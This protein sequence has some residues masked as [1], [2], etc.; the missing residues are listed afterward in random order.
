MR[1]EA[2]GR[3]I[4]LASAEQALLVM[5]VAFALTVIGTRWFLA[6]TGF[7]KIGGGDLH[8]AHALWGGALLFIGSI[9][10]LVWGGRTIHLWAAALSGAGFGLFVDEVG[11][12]I[13]TGNDYFYPAAAPIIYATFLL[14]VLGYLWVRRSRPSEELEASDHLA[15]VPT[16][17]ERTHA[18]SEGV[19]SRAT[20][21]WRERHN[22]WRAN[23]WV[24]ILA[25]S[26]LLI[27][28][29]GAVAGLAIFSFL[30]IAVV[31]ASDIPQLGLIIAHVVADGVSG[32]LMFAGAVLLMIGR[33]RRGVAVGSAGLL[34]A[35]SLSDLLSFYLRQFDSITV[36]LF[37]F[38]LF[39]VLRSLMPTDEHSATSR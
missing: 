19:P 32:T 36:V 27:A 31:P 28:G 1:A 35:L 23:R 9:L 24:R 6:L 4:R 18:S 15:T 11:K 22:R 8:I 14:S 39:L 26:A 37:H 29:L 16:A 33:R 13:T 10:P 17:I 7:P 30:L 20:A 5:L 25:I 3:P 38:A 21:W 12:F 34:V 2:S